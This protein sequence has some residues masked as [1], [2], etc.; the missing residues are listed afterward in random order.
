MEPFRTR[1]AATDGPP[2]QSSFRPESLPS[3]FGTW[4]LAPVAAPD[5]SLP[6]LSGTKQS[7]SGFRGRQVLLNFWTTS[8]PSCKADLAVFNR[9]HSKWAAQ[10]LELVSLNLNDESETAT[11]R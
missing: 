2:P 3:R 10:G 9:V 8:A 11:V 6:D 4:L 7:L 5:F 1:T